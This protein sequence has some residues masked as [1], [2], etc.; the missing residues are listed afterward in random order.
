MVAFCLTKSG[1]L[2]LQPVL[3]IER[4][5]LC[6]IKTRPLMQVDRKLHHQVYAR[7]MWMELSLEMADCLMSR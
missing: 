3:I 4:P 6:V 7:L 2:L 5:P 1:S